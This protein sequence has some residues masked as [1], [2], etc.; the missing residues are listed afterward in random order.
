M[1]ERTRHEFS[2]GRDK[3]RPSGSGLRELRAESTGQSAIPI[4]CLNK[5]RARQRLVHQP[6]Q[7]PRLYGGPDCLDQIKRETIAVRCVCVQNSEA[8]IEAAS[9]SRQSA[10]ALS[11]SGR[12]VD[13]AIGWVD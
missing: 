5:I 7:N 4:R 6:I 13:E 10:L 9:T 12:V 11:H 1:P 2:P 3:P 8:G